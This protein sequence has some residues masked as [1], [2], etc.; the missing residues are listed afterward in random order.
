MP[1]PPS[2]MLAAQSKWLYFQGLE[3]TLRERHPEL[4]HRVFFNSGGPLL[5]L[6]VMLAGESGVALA[7]TRMGHTTAWTILDPESH[8]EPPVWAPGTPDEVLVDALAAHAS[9][10]LGGVPVASPWRWHQSER[11]DVTELADLLTDKGVTVRR[12]VAGNRWFAYGPR[13]GPKLAMV[14]QYK[15]DYVE[16][17]LAGDAVARIS[18]KPSIGWL[19]DLHTPRRGG[20]ARMD[21]GRTL[22][23]KE[24][25]T[26][27]VPRKDLSVDQ[28][29][30]LIS[31]DPAWWDTK[32]LQAAASPGTQHTVE[33]VIAAL[34][35]LGFGDLKAGDDDNPVHSDTYH[36]EWRTRQ[37]KDLSSTELQRLNGRAAAAGEDVPK[38]LILITT[39]WLSKPAAAFADQAKAFVFHVDR[40]T[41]QLAALNS[42]AR[43]VMPPSDDP[44]SHDREPW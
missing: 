44:S 24:R 38:R 20:W 15:G 2:D 34:T 21:L 27:G 19:I 16:T 33:S 18:V 25:P 35:Q 13:Y 10:H 7:M 11:T 5:Y 17:E 26:P 42:R 32:D 36:V 37:S 8:S 39:T 43:E 28:I 22:W 12:V 31:E 40:E 30:D 1:F 3:H 4:A 14:G 9:A 6:K 29:A 41:G 23:N